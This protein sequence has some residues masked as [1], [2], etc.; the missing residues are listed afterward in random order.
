MAAQLCSTALTTLAGVLCSPL[1]LP[2][3]F[4][5]VGLGYSAWF[6]CE[7]LNWWQQHD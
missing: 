4:E 2:K 3:V 5:L 6:T 1:Q 7:S